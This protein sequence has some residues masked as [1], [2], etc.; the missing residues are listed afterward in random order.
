MSEATVE[1]CDDLDDILKTLEDSFT[2]RTDYLSVLMKSFRKIAKKENKHL[3]LFYLIIPA[4]TINYVDS[5]LL[6]KE[7]I[8]KRISTKAFFSDDGFVLGLAFFLAL[9]KQNDHFTSLH[10]KNAVT[11]K[12][13]NDIEENKDLVQRADKSKKINEDLNMLKELSLRRLNMELN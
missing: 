7:Q 6:G 12:F 1:A 11:V 5:A 2:D 8:N 13:K 4:L 3:K 9:L 10:W